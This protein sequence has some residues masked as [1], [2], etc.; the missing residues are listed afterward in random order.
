MQTTLLILNLLPTNF[1]NSFPGHVKSLW[2]DRIHQ[3]LHASQMP[4]SSFSSCTFTQT[5]VM[6]IPLLPP[7]CSPSGQTCSL[8]HQEVQE[9]TSQ[10]ISTGERGWLPDAAEGTPGCRSPGSAGCNWAARSGACAGWTRCLM[11]A[12]SYRGEACSFLLRRRQTDVRGW[13]TPPEYLSGCSQQERKRPPAGREREEK[14]REKKQNYAVQN[15]IKRK[16]T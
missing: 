11:S 9:P 7:E 6:F 4:F 14:K 10:H 13:R 2:Y 3:P 12:S 16:L 1:L 8:L 15:N 5:A